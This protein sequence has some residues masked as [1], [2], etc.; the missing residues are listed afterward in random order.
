MFV[1]SESKEVVIEGAV[2]ADAHQ[3]GFAKGK[4]VV[5]AG[6]INCE[7]MVVASLFMGLQV[8]HK[9]LVRPQ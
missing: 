4:E 8:Q 5:L 7:A 3:P 2:F 1:V 9:Y 6:D